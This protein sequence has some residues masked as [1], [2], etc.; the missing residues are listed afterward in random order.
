MFLLLL[1]RATEEEMPSELSDLRS[2]ALHSHLDKT[3]L[4]VVVVRV[5][6]NDLACFRCGIIPILSV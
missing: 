1:T 2:A 3:F 4:P 6:R 5:A